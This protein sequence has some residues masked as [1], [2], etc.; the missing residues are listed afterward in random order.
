P[1]QGATE[2]KISRGNI[3]LSQSTLFSKSAKAKRPVDVKEITPQHYAFLVTE[4]E[5]D[6]IFKRICER[7]MDYWADPGQTRLGQMNYNDGGRG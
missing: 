1:K 5:F 2:P 7:K 4:T 6:D 3:G